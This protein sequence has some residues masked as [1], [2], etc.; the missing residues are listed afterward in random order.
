M[1]VITAAA[2]DRP[3]ASIVKLSAGFAE[4]FCVAFDRD[5]ERKSAGDTPM[6]VVAVRIGDVLAPSGT[7]MTKFRAQIESGGPV[8][9]AHPDMVRHFRTA[10]EACGLML[11]ACT[12]GLASNPPRP[13]IYVL[14][15][16][17][18]VKILDLANRMIRLSGREPG[19]D[20]DI[21]YTGLQEADTLN[22]RPDAAG[23]C[24]V[25]ALS[26]ISCPISR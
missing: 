2:D 14:D 24:S 11:A 3:P 4:S 22:D 8:T 15:P 5:V 25:A 7:V 16:G 12:Q 17:P 10:T 19:H 6:R 1:V 9:V 26:S 18:P 21:V 20:V 13:G 23:A